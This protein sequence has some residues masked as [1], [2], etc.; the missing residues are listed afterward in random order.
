LY[1]ATFDYG[2]WMAWPEAANA[3][4]DARANE[5]R[6]AAAAAA[7]ERVHAAVRAA[8]QAQSARRAP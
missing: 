4:A 6:L 5:A 8:V 7:E 1:A 3:L 2:A